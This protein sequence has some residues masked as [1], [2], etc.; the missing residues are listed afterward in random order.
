MLTPKD[1]WRPQGVEDLEPRG[2]DALREAERS[3]LVTAGAGAGK[4]EFLAQKAAYLLHT[5]LCPTPKRILAISFKKD[6]ARNLEERVAKR[7]APDQARRFHSFTFDAFAK[8]LLDRFRLALPSDY[9]PA[10]DYRIVFPK[11][12]DFET[13]LEQH[14]LMGI[15]PQG[16]E[17]AISRLAL[18]IDPT[19]SATRA[20]VAEYWREQLEDYGSETPLSFH[21]INRLVELLL[22][23]NSKIRRALQITYPV[24]FLDE[25]QDTTCAQFELLQTA[26]QGSEAV[27]TA[28]GDDKQ[29][30]M[31]WAGAMA[32]AFPKFEQEFG[33]ERIALVKNYRSHEDLVRVQHAIALQIDARVELPEANA[34]REVDGEVASIWEFDTPAGEADG[35]ADW[36]AREVGAGIPPHEIA[37]LVRLHADRVEEELAPSM[38]RRGLRLR[39]VAKQIGEIALQDLLEEDL[40][41]IL[42]AFLDLGATT[43]S[44]ESWSSALEAL[45]FLRGLNRDDELGGDRLREDLQDFVRAL[46]DAMRNDGALPA[47]AENRVAEII[48]FIG[49]SQLRRGFASYERDADFQRVRTGF[50]LLLEQ[51]LQEAGGWEKALAEFRGVGQ[52]P[53][54]TIHKSKGLEFHTMIFF[55][56]D[57]ESWWSLKPDRPEELNAFYV[58]FTRARQR[59]FFTLARDRGAPVHWIERFLGPVGV[60][61]VEKRE[62]DTSDTSLP[63]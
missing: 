45:R 52:V 13:F 14:G 1:D 36:I 34:A 48:A 7:C 16:L 10:N 15:G 63:V 21:M 27:F 12:G 50:V 29:R 2:W 17:K 4:T 61:R 9:R 57:G 22:R 40:A 39:N 6:A 20:A 37:I 49:E 42:L 26:F 5:G 51:C 53:L 62:S 47:A 55:G 19:G 8:G 56:L 58:A 30:I 11:R 28:V 32:D 24:V 31:L 3:V 44:P 38:Q 41:R 35:L 33:A 60:A 46:R 18:P 23:E 43:R 54:M 59:A 25:F